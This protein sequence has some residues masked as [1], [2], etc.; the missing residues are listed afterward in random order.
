VPKGVALHLSA[1]DALS[2]R[3]RGGD[4][5]ETGGALYGVIG[6]GWVFIDYAPELGGGAY[7][8]G[9]SFGLDRTDRGPR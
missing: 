1:R 2:A 3:F 6:V 7:R 4:Y 9:E 5:T 8:D